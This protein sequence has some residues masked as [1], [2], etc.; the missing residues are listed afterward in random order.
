MSSSKAHSYPL[1]KWYKAGRPAGI[2]RQGDDD[3]D[4]GNDDDYDDDDNDNDDDGDDKD[5]DDSH[6]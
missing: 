2:Y 6:C 5:D 3:E 1:L 4:N